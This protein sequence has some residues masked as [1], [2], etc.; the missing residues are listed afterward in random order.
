MCHETTSDSAVSYRSGLRSSLRIVQVS[1]RRRCSASFV[2]P[3]RCRSYLARAKTQQ[4]MRFGQEEGLDL[5]PHVSQR[6]ESDAHGSTFVFGDRRRQ[7]A[8]LDAFCRKHLF[9]RYVDTDASSARAA[10]LAYVHPNGPCARCWRSCIRH[11]ASVADGA[12]SDDH[13]A[14]VACFGSQE[15]ARGRP[16]FDK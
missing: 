4:P 12:D 7:L 8:G 1:S 3:L 13:R 5:P 9:L 15:T 6:R 11:A 2:I 14:S 10:T 16:V